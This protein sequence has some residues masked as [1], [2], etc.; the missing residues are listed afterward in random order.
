MYKVKKNSFKYLHRNELFNISSLSTIKNSSK[1]MLEGAK[2]N[3]LDQINFLELGLWFPFNFFFGQFS[4]YIVGH[5]F[6]TMQVT[7]KNTHYNFKWSVKTKYFWIQGIY[8][9]GGLRVCSHTRTITCQKNHEFGVDHI[10]VYSEV[11]NSAAFHDTAHHIPLNLIKT[12]SSPI[13]YKI[14]FTRALPCRTENILIT[15]GNYL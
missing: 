8:T 10:V 6:A 11:N 1:L 2:N 9:E 15:F 12:S 7:C 3:I 4:C 14:A 13:T 5:T